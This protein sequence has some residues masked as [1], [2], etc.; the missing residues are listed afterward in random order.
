VNRGEFAC[1][2]PLWSAPADIAFSYD[3][4]RLAV[5]AREGVYLYDVPAEFR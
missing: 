4:S 2:Q 1:T 3:G 5:Y